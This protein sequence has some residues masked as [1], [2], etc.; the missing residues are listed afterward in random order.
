MVIVVSIVLGLITGFVA[1]VLRRSSQ[2]LGLVGF[3]GLVVAAIIIW[4]NYANAS[5]GPPRLRPAPA[6]K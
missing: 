1:E 2:W 6:I 5:T 3:L 4:E